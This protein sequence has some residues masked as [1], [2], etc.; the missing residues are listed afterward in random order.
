[1]GGGSSSSQAGQ[2]FGN[3]I[4]GANGVDDDEEGDS[5]GGIRAW[6][7]L[8]QAGKLVWRKAD[9]PNRAEYANSNPT[10]DAGLRN[11]V[12]WAMCKCRKAVVGQR[13]NA[14]I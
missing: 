4:F 6:W 1:M 2:Q 10:I 5:P 8:W 14:P 13:A 3:S 7:Y 12:L 11:R 9:P